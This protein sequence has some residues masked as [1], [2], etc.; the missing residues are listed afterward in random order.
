M[1]GQITPTG[2]TSAPGESEDFG[3]SSLP[4]GWVDFSWTGGT[5]T[6]GDGVLTVNGSRANPD[7]YT[8]TPGRSMEFVATFGHDAFEHA[9]FGGSVAAPIGGRIMRAAVGG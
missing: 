5:S 1:N 3:G 7:P 6:V 2:G 9:G 8:A 4:A